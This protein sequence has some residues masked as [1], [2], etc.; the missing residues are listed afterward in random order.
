MV[1]PV[2]ADLVAEWAQ[3]TLNCWF[4]KSYT[5]VLADERQRRV[6]QLE[7]PTGKYNLYRIEDKYGYNPDRV[8]RVTITVEEVK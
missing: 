6:I 3:D 1:D 5:D 2:T 7:D 8:F 4:H